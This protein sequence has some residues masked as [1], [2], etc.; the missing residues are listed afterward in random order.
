M[1]LRNRGTGDTHI[2]RDAD[3]QRQKERDR[4]RR[5]SVLYP[6]TRFHHCCVVCSRHTFC[7]SIYQPV[8]LVLSE[9]IFSSPFLFLLF[10]SHFMILDIQWPFGFCFLSF[11]PLHINVVDGPTSVKKAD[12][13]FIYLPLSLYYY[14]VY[15]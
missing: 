10:P 6:K 9:K 1:R 12:E 14:S 8:F 11:L 7:F 4:F 2:Q 3:T 5:R 15:E 13:E